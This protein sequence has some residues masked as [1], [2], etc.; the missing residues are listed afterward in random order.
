[1]KHQVICSHKDNL[2]FVTR[3]NE[4]TVVLDA[5]KETDGNDEGPRPKLLILAAL[6]G[7]SGMDVVSILKKMHVEYD[8]FTIIADG[9]LTDEHPKIYQSIHL[10]Y[11]FKGSDLPLDKINKAITLSIDKYCG[12][13]AMLKKAVPI[14]FEIKL[15]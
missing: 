7:C 14:S 11:G 6:A 1:M 15:T 4:H 3:I 2:S 13:Y 12:V 10:T 5:G 9:D 8:D